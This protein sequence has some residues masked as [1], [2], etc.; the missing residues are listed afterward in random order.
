MSKKG[1]KLCLRKDRHVAFVTLDGHR[2]YLGK[3]GTFETVKKYQEVIKNWLSKQQYTS[4]GFLE[5][6]SPPLFPGTS[7]SLLC[8]SFLEHAR[9]YYVKDG[10]S[11]RVAERFE[12]A[13]EFV[14]SIYGDSNSDDFSAVRLRA[15]QQAMLESRR[16][17]RSYLNQLINCVRAV[18]KW[19][20]CRGAVSPAVLLGLQ[21]VPGLKVGRTSARESPTVTPVDDE[22]IQKTAAFASRVVADLIF[23]IHY[24]GCRPGEA[25][26]L[27]LA[28]VETTE[29]VWKYYPRSYKTQHHVNARRRVVPIA[30][31]VKQLLKSY[32]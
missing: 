4:N 26:Q 3:Y 8:E 21:V 2:V 10:K 11:T 29:P 13:C 32:A 7:V 19:G 27:R 14:V 1:P 12:T 15:V 30:G 23:F 5:L 16:F 25:F 28:D 18:F 17:C 6:E 20:V 24:T 31:E 9:S 22:T